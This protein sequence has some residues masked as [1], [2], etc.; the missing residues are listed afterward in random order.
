[1][2]IDR[3][4]FFHA[5]Y[6]IQQKL[7]RTFREL[8]PHSLF[9]VDEYFGGCAKTPVSISDFRVETESAPK[10]KQLAR[11]PIKRAA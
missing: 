6:R 1:L 7:G 9:P 2:N 5:L 10:P 3:G 8:E 4:L 11:F